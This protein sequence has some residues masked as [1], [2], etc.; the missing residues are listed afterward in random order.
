MTTRDFPEF[1]LGWCTKKLNSFILTDIPWISSERWWCS[2]IKSTAP[3]ACFNSV[4]MVIMYINQISNQF[5]F[6]INKTM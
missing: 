5:H 3:Q 1:E 4:G 2:G 6:Q